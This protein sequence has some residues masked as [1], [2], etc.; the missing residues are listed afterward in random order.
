MADY[1]LDGRHPSI[2]VALLHYEIDSDLL[3]ECLQAAEAIL[4]ETTFNRWPYVPVRGFGTGK[5]RPESFIVVLPDA[6]NNE[7]MK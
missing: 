7:T 6:A 4:D 3:E 1:D 5:L 2:Q